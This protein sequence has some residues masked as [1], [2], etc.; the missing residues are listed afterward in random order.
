MDLLCVPAVCL[1]CACCESGAF[2][3]V[4]KVK[5]RRLGRMYAMKQLA[6]GQL[7][8]GELWASTPDKR[9]PRTGGGR[10]RTAARVEESQAA[11][12]AQEVAILSQLE[13]PHIVHYYEQVR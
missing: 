6:Q 1:V 10:P 7:S 11:A 5:H 13:H 9:R 4:Y 8:G 3:T 12:M 2:G